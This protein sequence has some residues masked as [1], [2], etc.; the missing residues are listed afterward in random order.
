[1][2]SVYISLPNYSAS[3]LRAAFFL[4][5]S[6]CSAAALSSALL[7]LAL[8]KSLSDST[9]N[10][11]KD[12]IYRIL[13]IVVSWDNVINILQVSELVSTIPNTGIPR[14]LASLTAMCSFI[15]STTKRATGRRAISAIEPRFFSNL[16]RWRLT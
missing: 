9:A 5:W 15:T 14:R 6:F 2:A 10:C 4:G 8:L 3:S 13:S 16:A 1:M 11:S 12:S 7:S